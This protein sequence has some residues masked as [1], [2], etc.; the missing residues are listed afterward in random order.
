MSRYSDAVVRSKPVGYWKLGDAPGSPIADEMGVRNGWLNASSSQQTIA[1]YNATGGTYTLSFAGFTTAPI[2]YNATAAQMAAAINTA[3][4]TN[5]VSYNTATP[6]AMVVLYAYANKPAPLIA[7]DASGLVGAGAM[8]DVIEIVYGGVIGNQGSPGVIGDGA[9]WSPRGGSAL[10]TPP[11]NLFGPS[12]MAIWARLTGMPKFA[13]HQLFRQMCGYGGA[14]YVST[15]G[16]LLYQQ[17]DVSNTTVSYFP[18][19]SGSGGG[20]V[21][22]WGDAH[23]LVGWYDGDLMR[24]FLDGAEIGGGLRVGKQSQSNLPTTCGLCG[25]SAYAVDGYLQ[26]AAIWDRAL[27]ATEIAALYALGM[28]SGRARV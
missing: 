28:S 26:H 5:V 1:V 9:S 11:T 27:P 17:Y 24:V 4:G 16:K 25:Y 8:V 12:T 19:G 22:S 23:M 20:G 3:Y 18:T 2:A 6:P 13:Y 7:A 21:V 10:F 15:N 14:L